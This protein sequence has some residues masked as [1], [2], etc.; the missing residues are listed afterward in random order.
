MERP[1]ET[2]VKKLAPSCPE[3]DIVSGFS[4]SG[5]SAAEGLQQALG[6]DYQSI[7]DFNLEAGGRSFL[8]FS[9]AKRAKRA[10]NKLL[11]M[12]WAVKG[13]RIIMV[14]DS[15][16]E[17]NQLLA[18]IFDIK[19]A[20]AEEVHLRIATPPMKYPCPFDIT[21]RG[22]LLAA[23]HTI[24]EMGKILGV[25]TLGFNTVE[26]FADSI[27]AAQKEKT[28]NP[29]AIRNLCL[30]CFTGEFPKY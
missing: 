28:E 14:D 26:D 18:R 16:V 19:E 12:P 9:S 23:S 24:K 6:I 25:K 21:P 11:I 4:M 22:E 7:F 3:A 15:I 27:I 20:G 5:N 8:P 30:G 1:E 10:R 17:G 13:K 29:I 2:L